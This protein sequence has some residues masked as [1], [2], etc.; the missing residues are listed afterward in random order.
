MKALINTLLISSSLGIGAQAQTIH[1][2]S[3]AP[4][5][6]L[7]RHMDNVIQVTDDANKNR[8]FQ[9]EFP[10]GE[11]QVVTPNNAQNSVGTYIL[12]LSNMDKT[13]EVIIRDEAG[14]ELNR[15]QFKVS[16]IPENSVEFATVDGQFSASERRLVLRNPAYAY[17]EFTE[18][19]TGWE[20]EENGK[21]ISTGNGNTLS[22]EAVE[23]LKGLAKGSPF[24]VHVICMD[25]NGI[26]RKRSVSFT[27]I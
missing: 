26:T 1:F 25:M 21:V 12:R 22:D 5:D 8:T 4:K 13:A 27:T 16:R 2:T 3:N 20:I 24:T 10:S 9:V 18:E 23:K 6:V 19:I 14:I 15:A 7:F 17:F 11:V